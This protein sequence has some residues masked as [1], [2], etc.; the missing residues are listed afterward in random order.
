MSA[1]RCQEC[2]S[3]VPESDGFCEDC[4]AVF[5]EPLEYVDESYLEQK[6]EQKKQKKE[7]KAKKGGF[8]SALFGSSDD[9]DHPLMSD[10]PLKP[11]E[12][13]RTQA[14]EAEDGLEVELSF[15][16]LKIRCQECSETVLANDHEGFCPDCGAY[17]VKPYQYVSKESEQKKA[18]AS[19]IPLAPEE[20]K[21]FEDMNDQEKLNFL[22]EKA[23]DIRDDLNNKRHHLNEKANECM[24]CFTA[25]GTL[26][27]QDIDE[28]YSSMIKKRF[29]NLSDF[30]VLFVEYKRQ[31]EEF[32]DSF[33]TMITVKKEYV[34]FHQKVAPPEGEPAGVTEE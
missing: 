3:I 28:V 29:E 19:Y 4:G 33:N 25:A 17:F 11:D 20:S 5:T 30:E 10:A 18:A 16:D 26:R 27:S 1:V 31:L 24:Q 34:D 6:K 22:K 21:S 13:L 14:E 8:F 23:E 2:R 9:F 15:D 12:S 7:K 32:K